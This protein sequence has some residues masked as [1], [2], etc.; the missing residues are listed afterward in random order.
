MKETAGETISTAP[1]ETV[2]G[3]DHRLTIYVAM[4]RAGSAHIVSNGHQTE[5]VIDDISDTPKFGWRAEYEAYNEALTKWA[6]EPDEPNFTPRIT[7]IFGVYGASLSTHLQALSIIERA[8]DRGEISRR[9][10]EESLV[11][12]QIELGK[13]KCIHTYDGDGDP[14]PSFSGEP[15]SVGLEQTA[16]ENAEK[17]AEI[18]AGDNFVS[19]VAKAIDLS[20]KSEP[21]FHIINVNKH[22]P[23][24]DK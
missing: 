1:F 10:F 23:E 3:E 5:T 15:Y 9:T 13:G 12:E 19:L 6:F 4:G 22:Q 17:Y 7:G 18:L 16:Q 2:E 14:I 8:T 24:G 21:E 11:P 20:G